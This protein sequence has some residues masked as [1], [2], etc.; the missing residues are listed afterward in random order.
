M[1]VLSPCLSVFVEPLFHIRKHRYFHTTSE[2]KSIK[3]AEVARGIRD[4]S[5][6]SN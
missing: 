5:D 1:S 3:E 6:R 2:N 4:L